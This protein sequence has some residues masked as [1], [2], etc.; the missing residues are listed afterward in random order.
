MIDYN[1]DKKYGGKSGTAPI[2]KQDKTQEN[3]D[4]LV[5]ENV[6]DLDKYPR[7]KPERK[8]IKYVQVESD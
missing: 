4:K 2:K 1:F 8:V 7:I 3:D 5:Y 6:F